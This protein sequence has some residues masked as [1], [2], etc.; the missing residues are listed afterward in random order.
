MA[1]D[2]TVRIT[3]EDFDALHALGI[4]ALLAAIDVRGDHEGEFRCPRRRRFDTQEMLFMFLD[5]IGVGMR[6]G[7]V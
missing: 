1:V 7:L 4:D 5:V 2:G 6:E 3:R